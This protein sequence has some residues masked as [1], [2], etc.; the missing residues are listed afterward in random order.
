MFKN[1]VYSSSKPRATD[2]IA[3]PRGLGTL[4]PAAAPSPAPAVNGTDG[5]DTA[6]LLAAVGHLC[7]LGPYAIAYSREL[8]YVHR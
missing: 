4:L 3:R 1:R 6:V 7:F 2:G 8:H 5:G